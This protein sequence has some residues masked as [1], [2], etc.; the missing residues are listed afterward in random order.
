VAVLRRLRCNGD[1]A[2]RLAAFGVTVA[3]AV[4]P[5]PPGAAVP[6]LDREAGGDVSSDDDDDEDGGSDGEAGAQG[7]V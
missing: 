4:G 6:A 2:V 5:V 1:R 7:S 3:G